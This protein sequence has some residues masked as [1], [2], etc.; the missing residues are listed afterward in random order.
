[1]LYPRAY[2]QSEARLPSRRDTCSAGLRLPERLLSRGS[3]LGCSAKYPIRRL[4]GQH[5]SSFIESEIENGVPSWPASFSFASFSQQPCDLRLRL[6]DSITEDDANSQFPVRKR[7]YLPPPRNADTTRVDVQEFESR[8][9]C[10]KYSTL[11]SELAIG[12]AT[13]GTR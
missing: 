5:H 9:L 12:P 7:S 13:G 1:M 6:H 8:R 11:A 10:M 2:P 4:D 3:W